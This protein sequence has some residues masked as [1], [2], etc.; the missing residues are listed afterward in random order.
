MTIEITKHK[1]AKSTAGYFANNLPGLPK[2]S[3]RY[4]FKFKK[5][6]IA[7]YSWPYY[8][9]QFEAFVKRLYDDSLIGEETL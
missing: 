4:L 3:T 5:G 7:N 8:I 9:H 2:F 6:F 1:Q